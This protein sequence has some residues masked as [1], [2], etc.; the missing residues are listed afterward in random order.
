MAITITRSRFNELDQAERSRRI[1]EG[2][3]VVDDN[4]QKHQAR[5]ERVATELTELNG[6]YHPKMKRRDWEKLDQAGKDQWIRN[7]G[8]LED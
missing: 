6:K 3:Q 2:V 5:A 7:G 1:A 4:W 8:V